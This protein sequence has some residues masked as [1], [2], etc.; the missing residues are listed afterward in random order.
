MERAALGRIV[1]VVAPEGIFRHEKRRRSLEEELFPNR[2]RTSDLWILPAD[3]TLRP[4]E[5][6]GPVSVQSAALAYEDQSDP[7]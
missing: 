2:E 5:E 4:G 3:R 1:V 6:S 7:L